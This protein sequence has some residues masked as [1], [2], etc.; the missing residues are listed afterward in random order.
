MSMYDMFAADEHLEAEGVWVD[1]GD[2]R[3]LLARVGLSLRARRA[4]D[5]VVGRRRRERRRLK[6][7]GAR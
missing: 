1:Y 5:S 7:H 2:F 6:Q 3:V 4:G